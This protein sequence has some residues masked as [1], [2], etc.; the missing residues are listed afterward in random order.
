LKERVTDPSK[1]PQLPPLPAADQIDLPSYKG[2]QT[3]TMNMFNAV[4]TFPNPDQCKKLEQVKTG[5]GYLM[6]VLTALGIIMELFR[7]VE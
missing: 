4:L 1:M 3:I 2:C 5:L 6:Y 7:R